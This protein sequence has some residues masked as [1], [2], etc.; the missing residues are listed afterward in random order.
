MGMVPWR[1]GHHAAQEF[2]V[3]P[4]GVRYPEGIAADPV[5]GDIF[6]ATFDFGPNANKLMRFSHNGKLEAVRDFG[7]TPMLG[8]AFEA[9]HGKVWILNMGASKVQRI[10]AKRGMQ[11]AAVDETVAA[12][13]KRLTA[14]RQPR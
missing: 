7:G 12:V 5:S 10:A 14:N 11:L 2:A 4:D 13:E 6:V 1:L 3:L 9:A 8:L